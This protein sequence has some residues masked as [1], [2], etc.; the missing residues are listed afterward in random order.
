MR[1]TIFP[2]PA[3]L[4][5]PRATERGMGL[6][7]SGAGVFLGL[8]T[9]L[10]TPPP[11]ARPVLYGMAVA[12]VLVGLG[13]RRWAHR[14]TDRLLGPVGA[15]VFAF[16]LGVLSAAQ[17]LYSNNPTDLTW[18][19]FSLLAVE[20]AIRY[21]LP[22]A[23]ALVIVFAVVDGA[24]QYY[25]QVRL[26]IPL[27]AAS[28]TFRI[29]MVGLL[30]LFF[31]I[32]VRQR[33]RGLSI[34]R[35]QMVQLEALH[36]VS[37]VISGPPSRQHVLSGILSAVTAALEADSAFAAMLT[38]DG[39]E[40]LVQEPSVGLPGGGAGT[41]HAIPVQG[42]LLGEAVRTGRVVRS[43]DVRVD[44]RAASD[45]ARRRA[46]EVRSAI[47]APLEMEGRVTGA[48]LV[49]RNRTPGFSAA[50]EPLLAAIASQAAVILDNARLYEMLAQQ[51]STD[52]LSGLRNRRAFL[53]ALAQELARA[54]RYGDSFALLSM[55]MDGLK[56]VN[57]RG[58]HLSGDRALRAMSEVL[59]HEV[60]QSDT[61]ARVGG[62]EFAV[63]MPMAGLVEARLLA[64]RV[65]ASVAS[66]V[67]AAI[68]LPDV[69]VTVSIGGVVVRAGTSDEV[70]E[71][72]DRALYDAKSAGRNRVVIVDAT[73]EA[74]GQTMN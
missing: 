17:V 44:P 51:A 61:V 40:L 69:P 16:D 52:E 60:R 19:A 32:V 10:V 29:G 30:A 36:R 74:A 23:V 56:A 47:C 50:D 1:S 42:S 31:A 41:D 64:E 58:G 26:G 67:A 24:T 73:D 48:L 55:D 8:Q 14:L 7:R 5:D 57:D 59:R 68:M 34:V 54:L 33:D 46:P 22:G 11:L 13:A 27:M 39:S 21:V 18:V 25:D 28:V 38:D 9:T 65:R 2:R 53:A 45:L 4:V 35:A 72:A 63:L 3:G 12:L 66:T 62:D 43:E 15:G 70:L 37:S 20:A 71:R 49:S 6:I